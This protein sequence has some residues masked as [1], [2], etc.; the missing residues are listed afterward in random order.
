MFEP[1]LDPLEG[2]AQNPTRGREHD[3]G[4]KH[5]LFDPETAAA[6]GRGDQSQAVARHLERAGHQRVQNERALEVRP[7]GIALGRRLEMGDDAGAL[8]RCCRLT[9]VTPIQPDDMIGGGERG[10]RVAVGKG[11]PVDPVGPGVLVHQRRVIGEC[12]DRID[13]R[14]QRLV[15]DRDR[16]ER[17]LG[18]IAIDRGDQRDRLADVAHLV[19]RHRRHA[20]RRADGARQRFCQFGDLGPGDHAKHPIEAAGAAGIDSANLRVGMGRAQDRDMAQAR[21]RRH[22]VDKPRVAG[23]QRGILLTRQAR[24]D[25]GVGG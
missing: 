18:G 23:Q 6:V 17:V 7:H 2:R 4:G 10:V 5:C 20:D 9:G 14:G 1:V 22:V 12:L 13:D 21:H 11:A 19:H 24:A 3:D 15:L 8:H 16:I 25:P